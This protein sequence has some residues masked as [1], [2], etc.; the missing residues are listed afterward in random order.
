MPMLRALVLAA[1]LPASAAAQSFSLVPGPAAP[2]P[3]PTGRGAQGGPGPATGPIRFVH[4]PPGQGAR[5]AF[6]P[7]ARAMF[8]D[9]DGQLMMVPALFPAGVHFSLAPE[10]AAFFADRFEGAFTV[11]R[12]GDV[13]LALADGYVLHSATY[14]DGVLFI[15]ARDASG[16]FVQLGA[17]HFAVVR[18]DGTRL[19]AQPA[20]GA[21]ARL[22]ILADRSGSMEGFD[23]A[24]LGALA[25]VAAALPDG[26]T[27]GLYEFGGSVRRLVAPGRIDCNK[28]LGR[29]RMSRP[30]GGTPLFEAM[31]A[32][33][34]DLE[35]LD[36][37]GSLIVLSDG[38]PTDAP[39]P[40]L[41]AQSA[42]IPTLVLWIGRHNANHLARYSTAHAVSQ[43]ATPDEIVDFIRVAAFAAG[44][45]QA[46]QLTP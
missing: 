5:F 41:E 34:R 25:A 36:G 33:Y 21:A 45:H 44:G 39:W 4:Q 13:L 46:W 10:G 16:T 15:L 30:D 7:P 19:V 22:A 28:V 8:L 40:E 23:A 37:L 12:V 24:F 29:Y 2:A 26:L 20:A 27:C 11:Y 32:A 9:A 18:P 14:R 1:L 38:E 6:V 3:A 43:N 35:A 17:G 31:G 42:R